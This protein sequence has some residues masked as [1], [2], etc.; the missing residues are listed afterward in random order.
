ME[1]LFVIMRGVAT[2]AEVINHFA[3]LL[4][5]RFRPIEIWSIKFHALISHLRDG[6]DRTFKVLL[7]R[8][9]NRIQ[10]E[11][12]GNVGCLALDFQCPWKRCGESY[13]RTASKRHAGDGT[14]VRCF[15]PTE[16]SWDAPLVATFARCG[17]EH[18]LHATLCRNHNAAFN[19]RN[20]EVSGKVHEVKWTDGSRNFHE[21]NLA[22]S[23]MK[24][25]NV[26]DRVVLKMEPELSCRRL[27][28]LF[29]R[30]SQ[31][32]PT[33]RVVLLANCVYSFWI[34]RCCAAKTELVH[35]N[36]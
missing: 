28:V 16:C 29:V 33:R 25:C 1:V 31:P 4:R 35:R 3:D 21:I 32:F 5:L 23:G 9:S 19:L 36:A 24:D 2:D 12:N 20:A 17:I 22:F 26:A 8:L 11:T 30:I 6:A 7:E 27:A 34:V 10:L 18:L 14:P 15:S 13:E